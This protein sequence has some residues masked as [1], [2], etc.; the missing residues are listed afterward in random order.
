MALIRY[1]RNDNHS[2]TLGTHVV[3]NEILTLGNNLKYV[4][5][6]GRA[7]LKWTL[8][9]HNMTDRAGFI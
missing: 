5:A 3:L 9:K 7:K 2:E 4:S 6:N 1:Y 8:K